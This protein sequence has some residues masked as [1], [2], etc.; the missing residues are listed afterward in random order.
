MNHTG[1]EGVLP[2]NNGSIHG[3][4]YNLDLLK[5]TAI[6]CMLI[7]HPII[8]FGEYRSGYENDFLYFMADDIIGDY[9]VA[10]HGFMF[11]M[12]VGMVFSRKNTAKDMIRRGF[13]LFLLGYVLN[14]FRYGIY[15][16]GYAIMTGGFSL[17]AQDALFCPDILHFAGLAFIA[18]GVFMKLKLKTVPILVISVI[19]STIGASAAF[20]D[21][22]NT[23]LNYVC[24]AFI[25][26]SEDFSLFCFF[27]WYIF[28]AA[29]L[30]FGTILQKTQ[31][32]DLLYKRLLIASG[33][34]CIIYV[35]CSCRF[36]A[37]FLSKGGEYYVASPPEAVGL[38]SIDFLVLSLFYFLL[39]KTGASKFRIPIEMSK[40]ITSIYVIH[41]LILGF[42]ESVCCYMLGIV[43]DYPFI[44]AYG[45]AL[46]VVSFLLAR[47]Y[48][49]FKRARR[50]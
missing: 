24:G 15:A 12:G 9:I 7:C 28:V 14:F 43:F 45:A 46:M 6:V 21:T 8:R 34:V 31:D 18:T 49:R 42:T 13:K 22:G 32:R 39:Q 4:Q 25:F 47:L 19:L 26:A 48:D 20:Y 5:A 3:R 40:N 29:G 44:L 23:V 50:S 37:F 11:A 17:M 2:D 41:W 33:T 30:L 36:G 38:L 27:N 1:P 10:A 16:L 35:A